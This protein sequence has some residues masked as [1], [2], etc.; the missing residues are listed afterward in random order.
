MIE[1]WPFCE[2]RN[3]VVLTTKDVVFGDS[4]IL[5]VYHGLDDGMWQFHSHLYPT[6]DE[7]SV[8]ALEVVYSIDKSIGELS[9]LPLGYFA[10]RKTKN[11]SW[12]I[13]RNDEEFE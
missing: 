11:D 4:D 12:I 9:D 5:Y 10:H 3:V 2:E 8:V 7:A 6:K 13:E 1:D